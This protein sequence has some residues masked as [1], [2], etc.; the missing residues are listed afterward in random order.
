MRAIEAERGY[1]LFSSSV[2]RNRLDINLVAIRKAAVRW[3]GG[4]AAASCLYL[5]AIADESIAEK[6]LPSFAELEAAGAVIGEIRIVNDNIFDLD[7]P[8]E[9]NFLFRLANKLHIR[10]RPGVIERTLLFH[11]GEPLSVQLI[12]ESERLLRMNHYIYDVDIHPIAWHDRIVDIEVKT[13]DT[14]TLRPSYSFSRSGGSNSTSLSL[15]EYNLLGTGTKLRYAK[16]SDIDRNGTEY[17]VSHDH[18]FDGWTQIELTL[19][20]ND[21][22]NSHSIRVERPF[23]ALDTRWAA[24]ASALHDERIDSIYQDGDIVG[25]YRHRQDSGEVY[26]GW[27]EG[28][29]DNWTQRYSTGLSYQADAYTVDPSLIAPSDVPPDQTLVA[30]FVRYELIEND[31]EKISNRDKIQR[32]EFFEMGFH[33][34]VQINRALTSLGST[35]NL[36]SYSATVSDGFHAPGGNDILI[37]THLAGQYGDGHGQREGLGGSL[38]YYVPQGRR[39]LFYAAASGDVVRNPE[40]SDLL[41]LGGDNGLRG[42]PARY[43]SG[44]QRALLT[45]EERVYTDWYPFRLIRVGG[46]VFYDIGRAWGGPFQNPVNPGWLSDVGFGLRFLSTRSAFGN[47]L[48]VDIA[49]PLNPDP[50]IRSWQFLVKS[51]VNF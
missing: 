14:W 35:D 51:Y 21:D 28:L 26:G 34:K 2:I 46:A 18:L 45:A 37:S 43:Q 44:E 20:N 24:G 12:E 7:D 8:K 48:H 30:P 11:S 6:P 33:S 29:V 50:D 22:G 47:I 25:Q 38:R 16:T 3:L 19:A 42:Y 39:G 36:W 10:T 27:S 13:R 17:Q 23:Y 31:Y 41:L 9:D 32:P 40:V 5:P 49:F 15:Q 1:R 4:C